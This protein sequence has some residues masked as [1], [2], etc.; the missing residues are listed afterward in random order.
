MPSPPDQTSVRFSDQGGCSFQ[1]LAITP[2][3]FAVFFASVPSATSAAV[4]QF[5]CMFTAVRI[6]STMGS[7]AIN[8]ITA[9]DTGRLSGTSMI[10]IIDTAATPGAPAEAIPAKTE[11]STIIRYCSTPSGTAYN[12]ARK[13][14]AT[15]K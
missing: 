11:P 1:S 3:S 9:T 6:G 8:K 13:I 2:P 10:A 14:V 5:A 15:A 12:W 7:I 4:A